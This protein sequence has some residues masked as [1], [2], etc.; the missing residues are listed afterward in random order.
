M[1]SWNIPRIGHSNSGLL[2]RP[3]ASCHIRPAFVDRLAMIR[4]ILIHPDPRLK[5]VCE[6]VAEITA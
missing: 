6:P 3:R 1:I 4:P 2:R 5:K